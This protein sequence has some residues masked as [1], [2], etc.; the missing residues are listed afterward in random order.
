MSRSRRK[1]PFVGIVKNA[2]SEKQDKRAY[3]RCFRHAAEQALKADPTGE[4]LPV[5]REYSD[6][7]A[8]DKD[9]KLRFDPVKY[10]ELMRK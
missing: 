1:H 7:W 9:G 8:M 2:D 6:P 10:P 4:S 3:N 5:L